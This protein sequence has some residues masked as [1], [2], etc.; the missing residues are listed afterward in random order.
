MNCL[1]S[2]RTENTLISHEN[3][4]ENNNFCGI[5]ISLEKDN[6]LQ[7]KKYMKSDKMPHII[8]ADNVSLIAKIYGCANNP[9]ISG[10][11]TCFISWKRLYEK[12]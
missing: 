5:A 7:F 12:V 6:I 1:H 2:F 4:C 3:V 8:F 10:S 9:E 11:K